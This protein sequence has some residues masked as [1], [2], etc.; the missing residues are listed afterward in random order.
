MANDIL[1][2]IAG[3]KRRQVEAESK[4]ISKSTLTKMAAE[5]NY[6]VPSM[7]EAIVS[8][9]VAGIIAEFKRRSPS[10]G[11]ISPMADPSVIVPAYSTGGAAASSVLTD[12]PF[13]GGSLSDLA[14]A[15]MAAPTLPL[16]RKDFIVS[17]YQIY[18][19]RIY[20]ASTILLIAAILSRTEIESYIDLAH[21]LG[22]QTLLELHDESELSR[23]SPRTDMI[24]VNNRNLA[25]FHTDIRQSARMISSL[26]PSSVK[27]AESGVTD[28][29]QVVNLRALGF[30]GFLIGEHFMRQPDPELALKD[31]LNAVSSQL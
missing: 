28:P 21:D 14:V 15:R 22:M 4:L 30:N 11:E 24:G 19:A 29:S 3:Y 12:T 2:T 9:P 31:F 18:Q 5:V 6:P 16:L 17:P 26:P 20:G 27:I 8:H 13:F 25:S 23:L 1:Q 7:S 10:K